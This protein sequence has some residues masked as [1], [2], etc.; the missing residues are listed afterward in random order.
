MQFTD[1]L[2]IGA[3]LLPVSLLLSFVFN[4][5]SLSSDIVCELKGGLFDGFDL[6]SQDGNCSFQSR[7]GQFQA[8]SFDEVVL[9]A[10]ILSSGDFLQH[11]ED[12]FDQLINDADDLSH[13]LL[14][15]LDAGV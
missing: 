12:R 2:P 10:S 14:I 1:S 9:L 5:R 7:I 11:G 3:G 6:G 13:S 15:C 8:S 4:N